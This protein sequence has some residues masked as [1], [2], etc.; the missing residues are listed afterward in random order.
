MRIF[1]P[2]LTKDFIDNVETSLKENKRNYMG[3]S[4]IGH[5]CDRFLFL[6]FRWVVDE[7][8]SNQKKRL[9]A[10]GG[11]EEIEVVKLIQSTG[12]EVVDYGENQREVVYGSWVKGHIDGIITKGLLESPNKEHILEIKTSNDKAFKELKDKGVKVAKPLHYAQMQCYMYLSDIDRAFYFVVNKNDD[13]IYTQR[14]Y[15]DENF[16]LELLKR[17][18][19][20]ATSNTMPAPLSTNPTWF[21][22]KICPYHSLCHKKDKSRINKNCRT[23]EYALFEED[24]KFYCKKDNTEKTNSE[25]VSDCPNYKLN[26]DIENI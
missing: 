5:K 22:C 15:L 7:A 16:A 24:G 13:E 3:I 9:L 10:R 18:E 19:R 21:E 2:Q 4:Y 14:L 1:F 17:G 26:F 20:I 23:C 12:A 25:Q 8:L 11:R 6:N